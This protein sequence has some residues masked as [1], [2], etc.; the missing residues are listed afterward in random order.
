MIATKRQMY[1]MYERQL[2]GN[3]LRSWSSVDAL[4]KSGYSGP[5]GVRH[6]LANQFKLASCDNVPAADVPA[7]LAAHGLRDGE[8]LHLA[9]GAPDHRQTIQGEVAEVAGGLYLRYVASKLKMRQAMLLPTVRHVSGLEARLV[10]RR[11]LSPASHDDLMDLLDAYPGCAVEFTAFQMPVGC[12]KQ[13]NCV[14]WERA[15]TEPRPPSR[16]A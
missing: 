12:C 16:G 9:E 11:Y 8:G 13:R 10:L 5:V 4:L 15:P 6:T 7:F 14:V 1:R 2:F 3:R